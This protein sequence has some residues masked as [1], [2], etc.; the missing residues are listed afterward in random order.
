[1]QNT[2]IWNLSIQHSNCGLLLPWPLRKKMPGFLIKPI[3]YWSLA[4][5]RTNT[6]PLPAPVNV[7]LMNILYGLF[8]F[9]CMFGSKNCTL[10]HVD[11]NGVEPVVISLSSNCTHFSVITTLLRWAGSWQFLIPIEEHEIV[12]ILRQRM[13]CYG[14]CFPISCDPFS[15]WRQSFPENA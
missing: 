7:Q 8:S 4:T 14:H 10:D 5:R 6:S 11:I 15:N 2:A 13:K 3:I 1:M 9:N 12:W